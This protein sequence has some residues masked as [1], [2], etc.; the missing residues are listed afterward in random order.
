[1]ACWS[2]KSMSILGTVWMKTRLVT[3]LLVGGGGGRRVLPKGNM[4]SINCETMSVGVAVTFGSWQWAQHLLWLIHLPL[5][6]FSYLCINEYNSKILTV[7][8]ML[9]W[10]DLQKF[11]AFRGSGSQNMQLLITLREHLALQQQHFS[12]TSKLYLFTYLFI[13]LLC[14]ELHP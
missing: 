14:P 12:H 3:A 7:W 6:W 4:E 10:V 1:M 5:E 8:S 13:Y 9:L 2:S 11:Q